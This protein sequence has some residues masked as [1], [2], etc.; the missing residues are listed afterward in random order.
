[1]LHGGILL[2]RSLLLFVCFFACA[3]GAQSPGVSGTSTRPPIPAIVG[4]LE[5][6]KYSNPVIGFEIQLDPTCAF[7][8]KS[9]G[10]ASPTQLGLS[11]P[12][13]TGSMVILMSFQ[14]DEG[15]NLKADCASPSLKSTISAL[16]FKK[17][18]DWQ[19]QR[20]AG[21][22]VQIQEL[23][24]HG[25]PGNRLAFYNAFMVGRN[26]VSIIALGPE[27]NRTELSKIAATLK[28]DPSLSNQESNSHGVSDTPTHPETLGSVEQGKYS[29]PVSAQT[30]TT[31]SGGGTEFSFLKNARL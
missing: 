21:T 6:G 22:D 13:G 25:N 29:N 14:L 20:I 28:I 11:I 24:R 15:A 4:S 1:M 9:L 27:A 5:Q 16:D 7:D 2:L 30:S 12:C 31:P 26:C 3:A 8:D 10:G 17:S 19:S 18:G 23:R